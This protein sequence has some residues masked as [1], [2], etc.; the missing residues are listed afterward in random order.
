MEAAPGGGV[1]AFP[2]AVQEQPCQN[3]P[4]GEERGKKERSR[5]GGNTFFY[6]SLLLQSCPA[7]VLPFGLI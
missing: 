4:F 5:G 3:S 2:V 6:Q 1:T 7:E